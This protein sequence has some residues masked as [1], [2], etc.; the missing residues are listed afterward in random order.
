MSASPKGSHHFPT[1]QAQLDDAAAQPAMIWNPLRQ[2]RQSPDVSLAQWRQVEAQLPFLARL[3]PADQAAL[4]EM[5]LRFIASKEWHGAHGLALAAEMQLSIALQAC[6]PVL[7]LGLHWYDGWVG[8]VVYPGDFVIPRSEMDADGVVHEYDD[9]VLG[10]AWEGG[11]VLLSWF[12]D[13]GAVAGI[14]IVIHEFAHKLDMRNG[15]ADGMPP[16]EGAT[17][18]Q[19]WRSAFAPAYADFCRRVDRGEDTLLDP[20]AAES[21][22]EFFAVMSEAFFETADLLF[23]EYPRVYA[24]LALFYR[25]E[26]RA[27]GAMIAT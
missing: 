18:A 21:P 22:A 24:Q 7:R 11:P 16:L 5:A 20:Y 3:S 2:R 6:L 9:A 26:P 17:S 8:I 25:Q 12:D 10:E 4:R 1:K 14:N 19:Q 13:P 27:D 23:E 15:V